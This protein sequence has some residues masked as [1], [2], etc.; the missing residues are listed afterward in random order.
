MERMVTALFKKASTSRWVSFCLLPLAFLSLFFFLGIVVR[1][2]WLLRRCRGRS[3]KAFVITVGNVT[4]GGTG[5]TPLIALLLKKI[6]GLVG[7]ASRGYRR[8]GKGLYVF[9]GAACDPL[10]SGDEAALLARRFPNALFAVCEDKWQAVQAL[11]GKCD[12]ILLDD[13]LQRYD[14]PAN[15]SIA[16][17]DCGCPDGY[18]WLL[19]RGLL[20]EPYSWL[21]RADCIVCMNP[22]DSLLRLRA[23]FTQPTVVAVPKITRFFSADGAACTIPLDRPVALFSGIA[24]PERFRRSMEELGYRVLDHRI[25]P[26]HGTCSIDEARSWMASVGARHGNAACVATEKDWA[27]QRWPEG[28]LFSEMELEIIEGEKSLL[29]LADREYHGAI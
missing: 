5:K 26:D 17:V 7:V 29:L 8:Q 24:R 18:G 11:D 19:P 6:P 28:M 20:R 3:T 27:R 22:N 25:L 12:V 4:V 23:P 21:S 2:W 1:R 15:V 16:T 9:E 10:R 14:I 13:G